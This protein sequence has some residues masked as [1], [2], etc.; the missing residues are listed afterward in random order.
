MR[1]EKSWLINSRR[2]P[3]SGLKFRCIFF[4]YFWQIVCMVRIQNFG[5]WCGFTQTTPMPLCHP[6][7]K[8]ATRD[9]FTAGSQSSSFQEATYLFISASCNWSLVLTDEKTRENL[10]T[11]LIR[12]SDASFYQVWITYFKYQGGSKG[13]AWGQRLPQYP[14]VT[15]RDGW[16]S[17]SREGHGEAWGDSLWFLGLDVI[18]FLLI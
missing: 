4:E 12:E 3:H 8:E 18:F 15:S 7:R 6:T 16:G 14:K 9:Q 5:T 10:I 2:N 1:T 11:V 13:R 17:S